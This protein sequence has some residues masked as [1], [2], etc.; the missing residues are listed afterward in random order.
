MV[1]NVNLTQVFDTLCNNVYIV[2]S[3]YRKRFA[4][5][6][7]IWINRASFDPPLICVH[8]QPGCH[9]LQTITKG[10]RFC[11][12]LLDSSSLALAR[13]FGF[14]SGHSEN[15]FQDT[16]YR[17]SAN[18]SPIMDAAISY[19]D[20]Q[21]VSITRVGDHDQVVGEVVAAGVV[22]GGTPLIYDPTTFYPSLNQ[23]VES[24]EQSGGKS[25]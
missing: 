15:K 3:A 9:T 13:R 2:T 1:E 5:C 23:R 18:G 12:N 16:G 22:R 14:T 20:C 21:V 8:L 25:G 6:T 19:F 17:L 11:I 10:Q 4:G 7:A 24:L